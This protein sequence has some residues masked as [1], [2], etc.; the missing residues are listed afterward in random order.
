MIISLLMPQAPAFNSSFS[1]LLRNT[2]RNGICFKFKS[3]QGQKIKLLFSI[4][5]YYTN[6]E[7]LQIL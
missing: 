6:C 1:T 4:F 2:N 3:N 7:S 5:E